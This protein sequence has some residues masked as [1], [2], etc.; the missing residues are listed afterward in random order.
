MGK[1]PQGK[2]V[3]NLLCV[4]SL[5]AKACFWLLRRIT[6]IGTMLFLFNKTNRIACGNMGGYELH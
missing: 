3:I 2:L 5:Y 4:K 6:F 1:K